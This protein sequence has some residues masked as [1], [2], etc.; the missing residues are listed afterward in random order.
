MIA[1]MFTVLTALPMTGVYAADAKNIAATVCAPCH[2]AGGNGLPPIFPR[3]AGQ[4]PEY[5]AKQ[6]SDYIAGKRKNEVMAAVIAALKSADVPDLALH[7]AGLTPSSGKVEN[8]ALIEV[9]K[10]IYASGN[11]A[12]SVPGCIGC[13]E[14]NGAG[15]K[16]NPRIAG[17]HQAYTISQLESFKSGVRTND[18]ARVMRNA[19]EQLSAEEIKAVA[20]YL[21][22][23]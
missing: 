10:N 9:G 11:P 18:K 14:P 23:Q 5:T 21:A 7:F 8:P 19:V 22:G 12:S 16:L 2:G 17:Q 4:T 20:E 3:L 1:A 6:L 13:H 15:S